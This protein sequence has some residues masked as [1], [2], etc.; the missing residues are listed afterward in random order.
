M[1]SI[2]PAHS[3]G[4]A[5]GLKL[6]HEAMAITPNLF[7]QEIDADQVL[8]QFREDY[9]WELAEMM[10]GEKDD[11]NAMLKLAYG[12]GLGGELFPN[13]YLELMKCYP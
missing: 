5:F 8:N 12:G 7:G 9:L 2:D 10:S 13:P 3:L 4:D 6:S 11:P 1:V